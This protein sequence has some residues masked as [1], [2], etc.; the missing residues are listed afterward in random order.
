MPPSCDSSTGN[1]ERSL[2]LFPARERGHDLL[3]DDSKR[4]TLRELL[5]IRFEYHQ[6][7]RD[8]L[9]REQR[10]RAHRLIGE[11]NGCID[12]MRQELEPVGIIECLKAH[13]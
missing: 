10:E 4:D 1:W 7:L 8:D 6:L 13:G 9:P 11:I 12:R 2:G 3:D 5:Q